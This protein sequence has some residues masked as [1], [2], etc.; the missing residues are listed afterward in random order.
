MK[1]SIVL[2]LLFIT[3]CAVHT[4][5]EKEAV[6]CPKII[7]EDFYVKIESNPDAM[8][9]DTRI[10][11]EYAEDRIPGARFAGKREKLD[12]L[13]DSVDNATP[14]YIYC[15]YEDRSA[16]VCRILKREKQFKNVYMLKGGYDMWK[17]VNL[18]VDKNHRQ[19]N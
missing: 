16:T 11:S 15:E 13:V 6:H 3:S 1:N 10:R 2:I 12:Q 8:V 17:K 9:L 18:P 7:P 14:V 5:K 19:V 4:Q